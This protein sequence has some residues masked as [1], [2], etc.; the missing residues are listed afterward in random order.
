MRH[1]VMTPRGRLGGTLGALGVFGLCRGTALGAPV[2]L[3]LPDNT[4]TEMSDLKARGS[5]TAPPPRST[6]TRI[7]RIS[8]GATC[9]GG[10]NSTH[11]EQGDHRH[12]TPAG[13]ARDCAGCVGGRGDT[14]SLARY[15]PRLEDD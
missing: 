6:S 5:T 14:W 3:K 1:A 10:I 7:W 15:G 2:E 12:E 11:G 4:P 13:D 8:A 9:R